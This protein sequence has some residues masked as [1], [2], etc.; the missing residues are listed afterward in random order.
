MKDKIRVAEC[1]HA[2]IKCL[3]VCECFVKSHN[4]QNAKSTDAKNTLHRTA[5]KFSRVP[6]LN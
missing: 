4:S 1:E 2:A 5:I 6:M 3:P